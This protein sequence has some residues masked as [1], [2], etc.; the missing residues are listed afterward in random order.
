MHRL[1]FQA[2]TGSVN[3]HSDH[4]D[5]LGAGCVHHVSLWGHATSDKGANRPYPTGRRQPN[6]PFLLV[7]RK[8]AKPRNAQDLHHS[9]VCQHLPCAFIPHCD[10]VRPYRH[11]SVQNC[12]SHGWQAWPR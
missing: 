7:Q 10:Y 4:S 5:H 3:S 9:S 6:T 11:Y 12:G 8:L 2:K 1:P